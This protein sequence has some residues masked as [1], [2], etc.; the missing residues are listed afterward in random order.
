MSLRRPEDSLTDTSDLSLP[1]VPA[2]ASW[3]SVARAS[4]VAWSGSALKMRTV[5]KMTW[6]EVALI[7]GWGGAMSS[8]VMVAVA[9]SVSS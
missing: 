4:L 3:V 9:M 7:T 2:T 1:S 5:W 8:T 6:S